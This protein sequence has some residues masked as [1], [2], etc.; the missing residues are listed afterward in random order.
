MAP[1]DIGTVGM[2]ASLR[3]RGG[4]AAADIGGVG[5]P[6]AGSGMLPGDGDFDVDSEH[7]GEDGGGQFGGQSEQG[8]RAVLPGVEPDSLQA[9]AELIVAERVAGA[10]TREEPGFGVR[11][12]NDV[13]G[14][15][16]DDEVTDQGC[17]RLG[18]GDRDTAEG[19][20]HG[21]AVVVDIVDGELGD[22]GDALRVEQEQQPGDPIGDCE[23]VIVEEPFGVVPAFLDVVRPCGPAPTDRSEGQ[24]AGVP[25]TDGP[26]DE[27]GGFVAVAVSAGRPGVEVGLCAVGQGAVVVGEPVQKVHGRGDVA[28]DVRVLQEWGV[29][30]AQAS[31]ESAEVVPHGVAVDNPAFR[32]IG[33]AFDYFVGPT[34]QYDDAVVAG[35]QSTGGDQHTAQV[36]QSLV[37][38]QLIEQLVSEGPIIGSEFGEQRADFW[39]PEPAHGA[40]GTFDLDQRMVQR[41]QVGSDRAIVAAE[42]VARPLVHGAAKAGPRAE[43]PGGLAGWAA[44]PEVRVGVEAS[45]AERGSKGAAPDLGNGAAPAAGHP[46]LL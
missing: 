18:E 23:D 17:Q 33:S 2:P 22:G 32:G 25:V 1:S 14:L 42:K 38:G 3:V 11:S 13:A 36:R 40:I 45:G 31:A 7:A 29:F 15:A 10:F 6:V 46:F 16:G 9:L 41:H 8:G 39:A 19:H 30:V 20:G 24:A 37:C 21:V 4:T 35:R 26:A 34:L 5:H 27:V 43:L 44:S 12:G 28:A